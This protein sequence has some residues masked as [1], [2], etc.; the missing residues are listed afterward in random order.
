MHSCALSAGTDAKSPP[1]VC[2]AQARPP[3]S[4]DR[5]AKE[6]W[7]PTRQRSER[8]GNQNTQITELMTLPQDTLRCLKRSWPRAAPH[9]TPATLTAATA[10]ATA[11]STDAA[12]ATATAAATAYC[13]CYCYCYCDCDC[14]CNCDC[15]YE[16]SATATATAIATATSTATATATATATDT[17]PCLMP[18]PSPP[19]P[20]RA[21][22][23]LL[24]QTSHV[25]MPVSK[26]FHACL[27]LGR[28]PRMPLCTM[29][30]VPYT[31]LLSLVPTLTPPY[32]PRNGLDGRKRPFAWRHA[33][34]GFRVKLNP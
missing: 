5:A 34:P 22:A 19:S 30:P 28:C 13:Y 15:D 6:T 8:H 4:R 1:D 17:A 16:C 10:T 33:C 11:T 18:S 26:P 20:L 12:N 3:A 27:R 29:L 14:D 32:A 31:S 25:L 21:G 24:Q 23:S 2:V 9:A 7:Q